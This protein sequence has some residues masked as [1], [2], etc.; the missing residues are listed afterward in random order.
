MKHLVTTILF[1]AVAD[2]ALAAEYRFY[3]P[4][5]LGSNVVVT[6]RN[7]NVVQR[8]VTDPFGETK[9]T[10]NGS[11]Q[12]VS[13]S[14]D[15]TRHLFTGHEQDPESGLHYMGARHYDPFVGKFLSVDPELRQ[16]RATADRIIADTTNLNAYGY[17]LNRPTAFVDPDGR[18]AVESSSTTILD[19]VFH[20]DDPDDDAE[21]V[22]LDPSDFIIINGYDRTSGKPPPRTGINSVAG[23]NHAAVFQA[24]SY[25]R[26]SPRGRLLIQYLMEN[27]LIDVTTH[28][29]KPTSANQG[30]GILHWNPHVALAMPDGAVLSPAMILAHELAHFTVSFQGRSELMFTPQKPGLVSLELYDNLEE[31]RVI[32]FYDNPIAR[33]LGEGIRHNHNQGGLLSVPCVTCR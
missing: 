8:T 12:S 31:Y 11:G 5:P 19:P 16:I 23:N 7:G 26:K 9:A 17:A 14:A 29:I 30:R 28:E 3:H 13:P 6:D 25:L 21:I 22:T 24:Q 20:S 4:D 27:E 15:G 2:S 33:E 1:F 10:I 18:F 32:E